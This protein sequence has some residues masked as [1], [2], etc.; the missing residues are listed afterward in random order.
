MNQVRIKDVMRRSLAPGP[1]LLS[2]NSSFILHPS[3]FDS[4]G[5]AVTVQGSDGLLRE[6]EDLRHRLEEAEET[7][8]AIRG[9]EVDAVVVA[10]GREQVYTLESPDRAYRLLVEQ[11]TQGAVTLTADGVILYCNRHFADLLGRPLE[12]L[13][14]QPVHGFVSPAGRALLEALLRE[15]RAG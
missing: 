3:S 10:A 15:G 13:L 12:D 4:G 11:M 8:R 5:P 7:L 14:G 2:L 9:G 6:N 1:F